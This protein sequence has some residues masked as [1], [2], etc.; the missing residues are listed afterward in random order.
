MERQPDSGRVVRAIRHG[1]GETQAEFAQRIGLAQVTIA[2]FECGARSPGPIAASK[3]VA[4]AC[5]I[6]M[7]K[8][9]EPLEQVAGRVKC[10]PPAA[11]EPAL[12]CLE[13]IER[14]VAVVG[15]RLEMLLTTLGR[16]PVAEA[17]A[18]DE[19]LRLFESRVLKTFEGGLTDVGGQ[20]AERMALVLK[21]FSGELK[22][23]PALVAQGMERGVEHAV[24]RVEA[25]NILRQERTERQ[26]YQVERAVGEL[27]KR[28]V[29]Q[30]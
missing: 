12:E 15:N 10:P 5:K 14:L 19:V 9:A 26:I 13:R 11:V 4:A 20:M 18:V 2:R 24:R 21:A 23:I 28:I 1:Y 29:N 17:R 27:E 30:T 7:G 25:C 16:Q 22:N 8:A 6:G 3:L